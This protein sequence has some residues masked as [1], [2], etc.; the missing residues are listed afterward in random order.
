MPFVQKATP[1]EYKAG[2]DAAIAKGLL[3]LHESGTFVRMTQTAGTCS[4]EENDRRY[5]SVAPRNLAAFSAAIAK[6]R[7]SLSA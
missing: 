6:A 4:R 3:E 1:A 2:L 5:V 7:Q